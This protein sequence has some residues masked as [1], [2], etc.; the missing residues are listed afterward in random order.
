MI[1]IISSVFRVRYLLRTYLIWVKDWAEEFG[2][3]SAFILRLVDEIS[4]ILKGDLIGA[5]IRL[6]CSDQ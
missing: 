5:F 4:N 6:D 3:G 1:E 2:V